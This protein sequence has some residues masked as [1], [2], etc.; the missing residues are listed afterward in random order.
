MNWWMISCILLL[1]FATMH[2]VFEKR[3]F[4]FTSLWFDYTC[5]Y[6][7]WLL[8]S[9]KIKGLQWCLAFIKHFFHLSHQSG[10]L[11]RWNNFQL[12]CID[13]SQALWANLWLLMPISFKVT[14][15]FAVAFS[16]LK[17]IRTMILKTVRW[18]LLTNVCSLTI[19]TKQPLWCHSCKNCHFA[20][21]GCCWSHP[22]SRFIANI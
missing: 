14:I 9:L 16:L 21:L 17:A 13:E 20:I 10:R 12:L 18:P 15:I 22:L 2:P 1:T 8:C 19:I 7:Q 6:S 11:Q 5:Q 4:F 3:I